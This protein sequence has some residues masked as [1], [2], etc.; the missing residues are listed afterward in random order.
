M[1]GLRRS[2]LS[3]GTK[4]GKSSR[5]D[6]NALIEIFS[7]GVVT[8]RDEW[9]YSLSKVGLEEK[10]KYL[11]QQ[12]D[13][14]KKK[15]F[16]TEFADNE[17]STSI[18]WTQDLKRSLRSGTEIGYDS[19]YIR[20]AYYRPF[21]KSFLY[22]NKHLN[23]SHYQIPQIFPSQNS[24]N[25]GICFTGP[26]SEK[27][28]MC[29]V[30]DGIPDLHLA[31]AGVGTQCFPL[32]RYTENSSRVD[33]I[34]DWALGQLQRQYKDK[35][36]TKEDIFHYVYAVLHH[37]AYRAKYEINLKREFP[38]IPFYDNFWKWADWGKRLMDLHLN[39]ETVEPYPLERGER[40]GKVA[41]GS[42]VKVEP[43]CRLIAHKEQGII[44][45]DTATT[46]RGV[47]AEAWEYRLGTYSALE[48]ILERYKEKKPKDPTIAEKFNT[49]RFA[50]YKEQ[51]I[52]LLMRVTTVSIETMKIIKEMPK[53]T[54]I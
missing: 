31:G 17:L 8:N 47:P 26:G 22:F 10:V 34:T 48:W 1:R 4:L 37:P 16:G 5:K 9:V 6:R 7:F 20:S 25:F 23:W 3:G 27:P 11:I 32:Y 50:E 24:K 44:E 53:E 43:T 52:D 30:V 38:R 13:V 33:N 15:L 40:E 45:V 51:V 18:K 12:Y 54:G 35:K 28:F 36:I 19:Q 49:Y 14:E 41:T 29:L 42:S 39:Y 46:L 2:A 21:C